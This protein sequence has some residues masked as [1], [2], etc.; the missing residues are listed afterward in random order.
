MCLYIGDHLVTVTPNYKGKLF[1]CLVHFLQ[2]RMWNTYVNFNFHKSVN[3]YLSSHFSLEVTTQD[4]VTPSF[5][6]SSALRD[7]DQLGSP[8]YEELVGEEIYW[9]IDIPSNHT[10]SKLKNIA[11]TFSVNFT[12]Y[13]GKH[14]FSLKVIC[15]MSSFRI[16][17]R[18]WVQFFLN[19]FDLSN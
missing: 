5:A 15:T 7:P 13:V 8:V 2:K 10:K 12:T 1:F 3:W 19:L 6:I 16:H 11:N 18:W 9:T 14:S 17:L 4:A